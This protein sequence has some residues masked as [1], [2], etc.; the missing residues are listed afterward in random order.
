MNYII[1]TQSFMTFSP[2]LIA[3]RHQSRR[4]AISRLREFACTFAIRVVMYRRYIRWY[5]S[6]FCCVPGCFSRPQRNTVR[7]HGRADVEV[8]DN[9]PGFFHGHLCRRGDLQETSRH[10]HQSGVSA[11]PS[12]AQLVDQ[13]GLGV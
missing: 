5:T 4:Y 8:L 3:P 10:Y 7:R 12:A 9:G 13:R 11:L 6:L 2:S 1:V